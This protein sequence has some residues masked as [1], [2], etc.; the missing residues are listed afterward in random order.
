MS[1]GCTTPSPESGLPGCPG[2][3]VSICCTFPTTSTASFDR[4]IYFFATCSR[5]AR[6]YLFEGRAIFLQEVRRVAI[7]LK[8]RSLRQHLFRLS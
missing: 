3:P 1:T 4:S 2:V 7:E 8:A 5:S 6:C